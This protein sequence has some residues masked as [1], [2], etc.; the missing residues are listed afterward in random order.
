MRHLE[1][2]ELHGLA[3]VTDL[4]AIAQAPALRRLR[5]G[6][7]PQLNVEHFA[8]LA[9]CTSL[10]TLDVEVGS[11]QKEREIYRLWRAAQAR[12]GALTDSEGRSPRRGPGT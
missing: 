1:A 9:R 12:A 7:M 6:A 10:R 5:V 3:R 8:P 2:L 11:R 4:R